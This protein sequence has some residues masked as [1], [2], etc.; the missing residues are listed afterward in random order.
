MARTLLADYGGGGGGGGNGGGLG[1]KGGNRREDVNGLH[2]DRRDNLNESLFV[3]LG[4]KQYR[5]DQ[6]CGYHLNGKENG[7]PPVIPSI[8]ADVSTISTNAAAT[9]PKK[10]QDSLN[11]ISKMSMRRIMTSSPPPV[12]PASTS[13]SPMEMSHSYLY[14]RSSPKSA[15]ISS[16][17]PSISTSHNDSYHY[18]RHNRML[19]SSSM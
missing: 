10:S 2:Q 15:A 8:R 1:G 6:H 3:N 17:L 19:S 4:E 5:Q 12:H 9:A 16:M 13:S 14:N 18:S 7:R 11:G